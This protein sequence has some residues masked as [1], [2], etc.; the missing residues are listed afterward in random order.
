[1]VILQRFIEQLITLKT[2]V[3]KKELPLRNF[4]IPT[5]IIQRQGIYRIGFVSNSARISIQE[6][7]LPLFYA[8]PTPNNLTAITIKQLTEM[9]ATMEAVLQKLMLLVMNLKK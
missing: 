2:F 4:P 8:K 7:H 5:F 3:D 1:M 9:V 6:V